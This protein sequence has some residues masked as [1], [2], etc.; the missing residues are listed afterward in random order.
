[1]KLIFTYRDACSS[2]LILGAE[3][4]RVCYL[5]MLAI[6]RDEELGPFRGVRRACQDSI[7]GCPRLACAQLSTCMDVRFAST[8][9]F[10]PG[11]SWQSNTEFEGQILL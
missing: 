9:W 4:D 11:V 5:R 8:Y 6:A 7:C 1:M 2:Q 3:S 10:A